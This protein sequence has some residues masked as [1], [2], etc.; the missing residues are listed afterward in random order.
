MALIRGLG[1]RGAPR[2]EFQ[3]LHGHTPNRLRR[4]S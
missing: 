2:K 1:I 4:K 3:R